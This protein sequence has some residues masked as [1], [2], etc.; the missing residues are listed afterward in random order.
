MEEPRVLTN[1]LV[2][3]KQWIFELFLTS[4][5]GRFFV[6][7]FALWDFFFLVFMIFLMCVFF[8]VSSFV[9]NHFFF[10]L[11]FSRVDFLGWLDLWIF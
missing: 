8:F 1:R 9:K 11:I 6:V 3:N 7:F 2:T 10:L 4:C 5:C